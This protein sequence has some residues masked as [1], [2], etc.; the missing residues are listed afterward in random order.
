MIRELFNRPRDL[1]SLMFLAMVAAT[2]VACS[3]NRPVHIAPLPADA[4]REAKWNAD[5][6][7]IAVELPMRHPDLFF[8][9]SRTEFEAD[10]AALR[11]DL[12]QLDDACA[13]TTLRAAIAALGDGH[14]SVWVNP[15]PRT[16]GRPPMIPALTNYPLGLAWLQ[17][18]IFVAAAPSA[19]ASIV[20]GRV[21]SV[22]GVDVDEA[23]ARVQAVVPVENDASRRSRIVGAMASPET[24]RC[25]G[26][27]DADGSMSLAVIRADGAQASQ[28]IA[29]LV[30]GAPTSLAQLPEPSLLAPTRRAARPPMGHEILADDRIFYIWYDHCS[31]AP[32]M[33]VS[34][35]ATDSLRAL[36]SA[37]RPGDVGA[38]PAVDRVVVD[39]RRN[40]GGNSLLLLPLIA[41][42]KSRDDVNATGRLFVLI[43]R[44]TYSSAMLNAYELD[45]QTAAILVGEPTSQKPRSFGE[46]KFFDC[47]NTGLRVQYSTTTF[48]PGIDTDSLMPEVAAVQTSETFFAGRDPA[49]EAVAAWGR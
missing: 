48:D 9:R 30:A 23:T 16:D 5:L 31:D 13:Y 19:Q 3:T 45:R 24:M 47:P 41:G 21:Q 10:L 35:F 49:I 22:G 44:N 32:D 6:D 40:G 39:L 46:V 38:Q 11:R 7:I 12:P 33:K 42:L 20:G 2:S 4:T 27:A 43:G 14:T 17:D 1:R 15:K 28:R 8:K 36:D 37:L 34:Q 25:L 26:L 18:G 29:P